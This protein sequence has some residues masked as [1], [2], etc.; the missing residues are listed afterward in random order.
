MTKKPGFE[1]WKK[2]YYPTP[3]SKCKKKD[4]VAHSLRKWEGL[5]KTVLKK[6]DLQANRGTLQEVMWDGYLGNIVFDVDGYTCAL[7]LWHAGNKCYGCPLATALGYPCDDDTGDLAGPFD[8]F[9][10]TGDAMPMIRALRKAM[11][12]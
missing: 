5:K 3:A 1:E 6:F 7:C 10:D 11:K 2:L 8:I 4:A 12:Q 9:K